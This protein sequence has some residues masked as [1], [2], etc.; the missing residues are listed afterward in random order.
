MESKHEDLLRDG[1]TMPVRAATDIEGVRVVVGFR[2]Q[3][4]VSIYCGEDPVFQFNAAAELR[5][6]FLDGQ[7]FTASDGKLVCLERASGTSNI[8]LEAIPVD[9]V[10]V[11]E[12]L[13]LLNTWIGKL[14]G[15][16]PDRWDSG[17]KVLNAFRIQLDAWLK[18]LGQDYRIASTGNA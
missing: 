17:E 15:V 16:D 14:R 10:R 8:R 5:R 4:Q 11:Q 9:E 6:V 1:R 3:G 12:I 2:D 18:Q 13:R 7:R